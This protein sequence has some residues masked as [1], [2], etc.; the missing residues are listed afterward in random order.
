[1]TA[2]KIHKVFTISDFEKEENFLREQ[3]R[4]GYELTSYTGLTCYRFKKCE[5]KDVVYRLDYCGAEAGEK[6]EYIQ[7]FQDYGW[8]Y[9]F[10]RFF[11]FGKTIDTAK[12]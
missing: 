8:E 10:D 5:P 6:A 1:M 3:H 11:V 9:L 2:K 12:K 7:M 4:Q